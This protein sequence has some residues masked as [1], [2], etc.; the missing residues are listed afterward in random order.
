MGYLITLPPQVAKRMKRVHADNVLRKMGSS[1]LQP[2]REG[3][4][5]LFMNK[6]FPQGL[7][8]GQWKDF[9]AHKGSLTL[10]I[11]ITGESSPRSIKLSLTEVAFPGGRE[12]CLLGMFDVF[13]DG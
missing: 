2:L 1:S 6:R 13:I 7:G 10:Q 12:Q 3:M 9:R 4:P 8:Q 11:K 5:W